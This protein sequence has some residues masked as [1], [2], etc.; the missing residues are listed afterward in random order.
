MADPHRTRQD[1]GVRRLVQSIGLSRQFAF[2]LLVADTPRVAQE[3]FAVLEEG[4]AGERG[5]AVHLVQLEPYQAHAPIRFELLVDE[6][7]APLVDPTEA[8]ASARAIVVIDASGAPPRDDDAGKL[9]FHRMNERRNVI[10]AALPG[11]LVLALPPRLEPLFA[12]AAPDFWSI[13]SLAVVV[14]GAPPRP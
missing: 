1:P 10:A 3:A 14:K 8:M 12:H 7:L 2:F 11:T 5:E 9:L 13:R 6:V 4:V